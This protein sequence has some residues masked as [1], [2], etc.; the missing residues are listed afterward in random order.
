MSF[1]SPFMGFSQTSALP[2][3]KPGDLDISKINNA[4]YLAQIQAALTHMNTIDMDKYR[5][6]LQIYHGLNGWSV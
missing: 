3:F 6:Y 2:H 4:T 1:R 5:K